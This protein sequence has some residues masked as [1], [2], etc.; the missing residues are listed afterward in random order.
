MPGIIGRRSGKSRR[1]RGNRLAPLATPIGI[2]SVTKSGSVMT[3]VFNQAVTLSGVP[4]YTTNIAGANPL[5]AALTAPTT[6]AVT[7]SAAVATATTVNI[8]HEDPAIRNT[9]GGFV[10]PSTFP[11]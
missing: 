3:I 9:S 1:N 6:V 4:Q 10:S 2:A 11:A 8:P 7:F 5:S